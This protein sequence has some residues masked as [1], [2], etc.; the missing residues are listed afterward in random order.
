[1][2]LKLQKEIKGIIADYWKI[3]DCDI[4]HGEVCISLFANKESAKNRINMLGGRI[5]F[6][7][8]FDL[9]E[10]DKEGIN[11]LSYAYSQITESKMSKWNE[12]LLDNEGHKILE[13][14][15]IPIETNDFALAER[16]D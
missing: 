16:I 11:P 5:K 12:G 9:T 6:N 13:E 14:D 4:K 1:M 3:V 10:L 15:F 7:I 8:D 2:A